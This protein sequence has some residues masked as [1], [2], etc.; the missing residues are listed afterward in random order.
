MK[1]NYV[2]KIEKYLF[3]DEWKGKNFMSY[4]IEITN[5]CFMNN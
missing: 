3:S 4:I 5:I 1:K 2:D